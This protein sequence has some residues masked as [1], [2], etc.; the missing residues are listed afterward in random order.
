VDGFVLA[1]HTFAVQRGNSSAKEVYS[2]YS[3]LIALSALC[4]LCCYFIYSKALFSAMD[5]YWAESWCLIMV[6]NL[7]LAHALGRRL[8]PSFEDQYALI[9]PV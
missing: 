8:A 6:L 4:G 3:N 2:G 9:P 7:K 5:F 1:L